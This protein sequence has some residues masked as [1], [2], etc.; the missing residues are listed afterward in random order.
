[1][2]SR[3]ARSTSHEPLAQSERDKPS[4]GRSHAPPAGHP[5]CEIAECPVGELLECRIVDAADER[6]LLI[7]GHFGQKRIRA[8]LGFGPDT[9]RVSAEAR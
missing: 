3:L 7:E 1:M 8:L 6:K 2:L 4:S 9:H 5:T